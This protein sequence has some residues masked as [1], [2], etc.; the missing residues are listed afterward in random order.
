MSA[1]WPGCAALSTL[2]AELQ[3]L[4][5]TAADSFPP[6]CTWQLNLAGVLYKSKGLSPWTECVSSHASDG[7]WMSY[8]FT[9]PM[10]SGYRFRICCQAFLPGCSSRSSASSTNGQPTASKDVNLLT[11]LGEGPVRVPENLQPI[12]ARQ[13]ACLCFSHKL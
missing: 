6:A 7:H 1:A 10:S 5:D 4:G 11:Q 13:V 8:A 12:S 3:S 9:G 2:Q